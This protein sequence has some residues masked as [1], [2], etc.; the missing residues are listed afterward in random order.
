[1][2][3]TQ[4][5]EIPVDRRLIIEIPPEVPTGKA[6]VELKVTPI[7]KKDEKPEPPLKCLVGV[8]TPIADSLLGAAASLGKVTLDELR[9]EW[10]SDKYLI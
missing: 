3:I 4:T 5:L 2:I 7:I 10:L 8:D 6:E 1:M 9:D